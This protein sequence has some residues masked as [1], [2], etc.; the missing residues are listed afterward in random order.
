[1]KGNIIVTHQSEE[2][3]EITTGVVCSNNCLK[4]C[5]QEIFIKNYGTHEDPFLSSKNFEKILSTIS[6]SVTIIFSGFCEPFV[7]KETTGMIRYAHNSG[8]NVEIYTTLRG[9][10]GQDVDELVKIPF[11]D[12]CLHLPD[13][14]VLSFPLTE[15]YMKNVFKV[16]QGVS[17]ARIMLM[18]DKFVSNNRENV[19][20]G[21]YKKLHRYGC[22]HK[23]VKPQFVVLPNGD[24]H[25]CCD[26]FKLEHKMGNLLQEDYSQMR[27]RLFKSGKYALCKTCSKD[28]PYHVFYLNRIASGVKDYLKSKRYKFD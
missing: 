28:Q 2:S 14:R 6:K 18:N 12:F 25:L 4:Y 5:P 11:Q 1:L 10:S 8:Y 16:L 20:R 17:S 22:C 23:R 27:Q 9:V 15:E 3:L 13:G 19:A 7:N 26:D 24:T 21:V